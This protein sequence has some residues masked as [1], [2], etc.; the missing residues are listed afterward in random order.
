[1]ASVLEL[2]HIS[3]SGCANRLLPSHMFRVTWWLIGLLMRG[4]HKNKAP[5]LPLH[6]YSGSLARGPSAA[7]SYFLHDVVLVRVLVRLHGCG[8]QCRLQCADGLV[9]EPEVLVL[10][11]LSLLP[12]ARGPLFV[13]CVD[14]HQESRRFV[15]Q[16]PSIPFSYGGMYHRLLGPSW[17]LIVLIVLIVL[18]TMASR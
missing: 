15:H 17:G 10:Q 13:V 2:T 8:L 16:S 11:F 18:I 6:Y 7:Q 12:I 4:T 3:W 5:P 14:G 9:R 1:M